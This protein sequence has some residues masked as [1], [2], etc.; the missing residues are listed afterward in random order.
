MAWATPFTAAAG[1]SITAANS[2]Q[3]RD[4]LKALLPLDQVAWTSYTPTLTQSGAVTKTVTYAK[5]TQVGKWVHVQVLLAVTGS[6]TGNNA[7]VVSLP[8]TAASSSPLF[9]GTFSWFNNGTAEYTGACVIFSTTSVCGHTNGTASTN[10]LGTTG[11]ADGTAL[12][13]TDAIRIDFSY[14]AA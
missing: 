8:V 6:G 11:S 4:N 12:A 5:Y 14:E 7:I 1:G 3:T 2:N 9:G 10:T 13:N